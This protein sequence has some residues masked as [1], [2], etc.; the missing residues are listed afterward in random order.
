MLIRTSTAAPAAAAVD[1]LGVAVT[2]PVKP[3]GA[4]AE[5][6]ERLGGAISR[7]VSSREVRGEAGQ[8]TVLHPHGQGVKAQRVAILGLGPA[9]KADADSLRTAAATAA[10]SL[11]AARGTTLA[12]VA[13]GLPLDPVEAAR[14]LVEG[15]TIG[16]YRFDSFKTR[17]DRP[18]PPRALTVLTSDRSVV[19]AAKRAGLVA[20]AVNRARDL[21]NTPSN[22]LGPVEMADHARKIAAAH[23]HLTVQVLDERRMERLGMGAFLAVAQGSV[24]PPRLVVLRYAPPRAPRGR[25]LG[26]VGK[27]V[28]FDSGG[29]SLKPLRSMIG[30]KYD[31]SGAAAVLEA[32]AAIAELKLPLR[33]ISVVGATDNM[34]D[35]GSVMPDTVVTAS[36]GRTIE[37]TNTDAEGRLVLADCLHHARNLGAT[38]LID[39]ATLT[40][41]V[42]TALGDV[43]AGMMGVDQPWLDRVAAAGEASGD[44][45]WPL[46]L[47]DTFKRMFRSD[48]A[49]IGNSS[50]WGMAGPSYAARFLQEFAGEGPWAHLDIAG[51]ADLTRARDYYPRGGTGYGVRLLVEL[52]RSLSE[53]P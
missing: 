13:D 18:K 40:G 4:A 28:T 51:T 11:L 25:V 41:A 49:D 20:D 29:L 19:A 30:M 34:P 32:T 5:L 15:A 7:L 36:N 10:R 26:M 23:P 16:G 46:P 27:G 38:H 37:I 1:M 47:S 35:A 50:T 6:D 12:L 24:R 44:H 45:V 53:A 14:C 43:H 52:A 21:Q 2:S 31:M 3:A 8:I 22:V 48:V 9:A 17:G 42:V 33:T 39:L